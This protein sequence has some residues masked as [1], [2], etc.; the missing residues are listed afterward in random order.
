[1]FLQLEFM[2]H[3]HHNAH[4]VKLCY[5]KFI[6][7]STALRSLNAYELTLLYSPLIQKFYYQQF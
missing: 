1:M 6:P 3:K 2:L 7:E 5:Y 4:S